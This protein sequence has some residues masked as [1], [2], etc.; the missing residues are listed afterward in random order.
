MNKKIKIFLIILFVIL[1]TL[2]LLEFLLWV[3][4]N[5]L[6]KNKVNFLYF[7][8]KNHDEQCANFL[9]DMQIGMIHNEAI[10]CKIENGDIK[11]GFIYYRHK[12]TENSNL[13]LLTLGG[14]TTDGFYSDGNLKLSD[15]NYRTW[16]YRLSEYCAISRSC[17]VINGGVGGYSTSHILRKFFRDVVIMDE[18]PDYI[19][20]LIGANDLP[21]HDGVL[22]LSYPYYDKY[23]IDSLLRGIYKSR[24]GFTLFPSTQRFIN[25]MSRRIYDKRIDYNKSFQDELIKKNIPYYKSLPR[26]N[27]KNKIELV[28]HN[29]ELLYKFSKVLEIQLIIFL[30]PTMGLNHENLENFSKN[31]LI[32][33]KGIDEN[34]SNNLNDH[35]SK[36]REYCNLKEYC[37]DISK[38]II[39]DG[40][41]KYIDP[42]HPN[43]QGQKVIAKE[44]SKILIKK[45]II[46]E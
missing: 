2:V 21:G 29:L 25:Y 28:S 23:Q 5:N 13:R 17:K 32:L 9:F 19:L 16:P 42:R 44:I 20:L 6:S 11:R 40:Q 14:S 12:G 45:Q 7:D 1:F 35:Y 30:E 15:K 37:F 4:I 31:D 39:H 41:D 33:R 27:F 22:E 38:S 26:A 3:G 34:Y 18:K 36:L 8:R 46:K 10:E 43:A 24:Y